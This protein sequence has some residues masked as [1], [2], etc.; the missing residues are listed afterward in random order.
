MRHKILRSLIAPAIGAAVVPLTIATAAQ[1]ST[2][3]KLASNQTQRSSAV[4]HLL[5][6]GGAKIGASQSSNWFGYDEGALTQ[7]ALF[8]Q[9]SG[10]WTVPTAS[11]HT[12]G[13]EEDSADWIGVGGGCVNEGC[14]ISDP[15]GLIQ[16]GTEQNVASGGSTSYGAWWELVPI[17]S[18]PIE[19][20][21]IAPGDRISADIYEVSPQ[22]LPTALQELP[23]TLGNLELEQALT[24]LGVQKGA[25]GRLRAEAAD[26]TLP[27]LPSLGELPSL[28]GNGGGT[29]GLGIWRI[30][31][32]NETTGESFSEAVPYP[33]SHASA[34]WIEET[35]LGISTSGVG[36]TALPN[37]TETPFSSATVNDSPAKLV[38]DD[39]IDLAEESSGKVIGTV[40][41]PAEGGSAFGACAWSEAC[42][43]PGA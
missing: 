7:G 6:V 31:L 18:I 5:K 42:A 16:T 37:L 22:E 24:E 29:P 43:A 41:E 21:S 23:S 19:G 32:T 25:L 35:P 34:E 33:S 36:L 1:A 26:G 2:A 11:Q 4:I 17:P 14:T 39:A 13:S 20:V 10:T 27:E 8:T 38:P 28:T 3:R 9:I 30:E 40:S 12:A 15:T